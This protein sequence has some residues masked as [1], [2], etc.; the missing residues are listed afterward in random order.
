M[1]QNRQ[2]LITQRIL[3]I[4]VRNI[5]I[6]R[7]IFFL[8]MRKRCLSQEGLHLFLDGYQA[9]RPSSFFKRL[10][11][12]LF[13]TDYDD[14]LFTV[15]HKCRESS[16]TILAHASDDD[17]EQRLQAS[18]SHTIKIILSKD[19]KKTTGNYCRQNYA[20]F[21]DVMRESYKNK[22]HQTA[23]MV[24]LALRSIQKPEPTD[25]QKE[26]LQDM[27]H[28]YGIPVYQKHIHYWRGVRTDDELPSLIAFNTYIRRR[29]FAC[30]F[31]EVKEAKQMI[32]IFQFL[33]HNPDDILPIYNQEPL[34]KYQL[35]QLTQYGQNK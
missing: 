35:K 30:R 6:K 27:E 31:E 18:V 7:I 23:H 11:Y 25:K 34:T 8:N 5:T 17:I 24:W 4:F 19:N 33:E 2:P 28:F 10:F 20:F 13:H 3:V 14:H 21:F 1:V 26:L 22:D 12:S 29:K 32:D 15:V 9:Y 16:K